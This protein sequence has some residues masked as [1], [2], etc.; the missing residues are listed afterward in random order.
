MCDQQRLRP[1]CVHEQSDQSLCYSFDYAMT[2]KLLTEHPFVFLSLTGGC[3][4][5]SDSTLVKITH[6]L[7]SFVLSLQG[8]L[9]YSSYGK[10]SIIS[11]LFLFFFSNKMLVFTAA[12]YKML[13]RLANR[14]DP[15][16]RLLF[17]MQSDN[18]WSALFVQRPI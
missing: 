14:E 1:A 3:T 6:C 16:P 17:Q 11:N 15:D 5:S 2:V 9:N 13:F 4:G 7:K 12:I 10:C 8:H 18:Y